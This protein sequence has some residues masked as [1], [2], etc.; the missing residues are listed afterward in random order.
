[1][2]KIV[3][4]YDYTDKQGK[5]LYQKVR[6]KPK[7]FQQR[8]PDGNGDYIYDLN[9]VKPVLYR[10]P[11]LLSANGEHIF[12][13]EGEKDSDR[14]HDEG[15][16]ATTSGSAQSW[17]DRFTK[18]FEDKSVV[19]LPDNDE[20]GRDYAKR[21]TQSLRSAGVET[22]VVR[23]PDLADGED[24]SDWLDNGGTKKR[25]LKLVE[26]TPSKK[27]KSKKCKR[28]IKNR[29]AEK[30]TKEILTDGERGD[31]LSKIAGRLRSAGFDF[32]DIFNMLLEYNSQH[33]KPPKTNKEVKDIAKSISKYNNETPEKLDDIG[34]SKRFAKQ[35]GDK[36]R[37][38][39]EWKQWLAFDG[40]R[41]NP[42]KGA[43]TA[44]QL[45]KDTAR[46][47]YRE[48]AN[49]DDNDISK[50]ISKWANKSS[51][52]FSITAMLSLAKPEPPL[53]AYENQFNINDYLFNCLNGTIDL[54][55]GKLQEHDPE[56]MITKLAPVEYPAA[57][58]KKAKVDSDNLKLWF[59]CLK[60]WMRNNEAQID[61][62]Q[63][64]AGYC[65]TG[66]ITSRVFPVFHGSGKNGKSTFLDCLMRMMGDYASKAPETLLKLSKN[67]RHPTEI[68]SLAGKRL[69]VASETQPNMKL[70]VGLVKEMTGDRTINARE[71]Y[72]KGK[73]FVVTHKTILMTQNL[74]VINETADAIWDRLHRV[75]WSYRVPT[76]QQDTHLLEKLKEEWP[77]ILTWA[78]KGCRKWMKDGILKPTEQ[79][80]EATDD[81]RRQ[82]NPVGE[83]IDSQCRKKQGEYE[84][85]SRLWK[86]YGQFCTDN[87]IHYGRV[88][89][90]EFG[91]C[92][93]Q[94]GFIRKAK[95]V[96]GKTHRCWKGLELK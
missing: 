49:C 59:R 88:S 82:E 33:C 46:E 52:N 76:K 79:I 21:V 84:T 51:S 5:L 39:K 87:K 96:D 66:D 50:S 15:L 43:F 1:M 89:K 11:E 68:A 67:Y 4:T 78:A 2:P 7:S 42:K 13:T 48:A 3:A 57:I 60:Q 72:E 36:L 94:L 45:A 44:T 73:D 40:T 25:L 24:V 55:T 23:L 64:L 20:A 61:Y 90:V 77:F 83:F 31:G 6:F 69:I 17:K 35:H 74:P 85:N 70:K 53:A 71:M 86:R 34:N 27:S 9:G 29:R 10:L 56:N 28:T 26:K 38:C 81:Y 63:R 58:G 8:R 32:A 12:I 95:R 92:L 47:I 18:L 16:T 93:S 54:R 41:W 62:L 14:L 91:R 37:Y 30:S 19:I 80:V 65:L 22:R 75:N